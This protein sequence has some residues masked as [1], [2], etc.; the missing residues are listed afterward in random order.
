MISA[1]TIASLA[2]VD[3]CSPISLGK[4]HL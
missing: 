3:A 1:C 4:R 2:T